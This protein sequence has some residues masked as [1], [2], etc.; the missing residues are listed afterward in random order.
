VVEQ[1]LLRSPVT[2]VI[3]V[4]F[5]PS[6]EIG[7]GLDRRM[8]EQLAASL[9]HII[10]RM[11]AD[12]LPTGFAVAVERLTS[13]GPVDPMAF[14]AYFRGTAALL[15]EDAA[16][17]RP[18]FQFL[19]EMA[20]PVAR[21]RVADLSAASPSGTRLDYYQ[22]CFDTDPDAKFEL[23]AAD[24]ERAAAGEANVREA[25]ALLRKGAPDVAGEFE[26]IVHELVLVEDKDPSAA[27]GFDGGSSYQSWGAL[28]L[29]VAVPKPLVVMAETL[30]HEGAHSFLFGHTIE[31]PLV[32][33]PDEDLFKSPLRDDPRPMDGIYHATFVTARMHYAMDR[34]AKSGVLSPADQAVAEERRD[35]DVERFRDG[36]AIVS[37]HGD[38]SPVGKRLLEAASDHM[39]KR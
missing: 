20:R 18:H 30:A 6:A 1:S 39:A 14:A 12:V 16:A 24:P 36:F 17:A 29:N 34:L 4:Q 22:A 25:L 35:L 33:N 19:A 21:L 13:G 8:R 38:L 37:E 26:A 23:K 7:S 32:R 5:T 2:I 31:E 15:D 28:A 3:P 27:Y 11:S 9:G 10:E